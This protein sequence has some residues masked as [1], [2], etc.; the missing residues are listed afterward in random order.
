MLDNSDPNKPSF[1]QLL[2]QEISEERDVVNAT[3]N[4]GKPWATA[5]YQ[6]NFTPNQASYAIN[7][8]DFGKV[9]YVLKETT[10]SWIPYIPVAFNDVSEQ[11]YGTIL[12]WYNNSYAQAFA[13]SEAPEKMAFSRVGVL[14]AQ[15]TVEI[16]PLPQQSVT[17]LI[18]Y[19]PGYMGDDDPLNSAIQMPEHAEMVRLRSAIALLP[20]TS[21]G[22]DMAMNA[23]KRKELAQSFAFQLER[24]EKLFADYIRS[25]NI[26]RMV[27][28]EPFNY[29]NW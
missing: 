13:L 29:G 22:E 16:Q 5:E 25:I 19:L 3:N 1:H 27:D 15:Y 4:S 23:T 12:A 14:N 26:P 21:W 10:N 18:T 17:Y 24:K 11:E 6:L 9:L 2:R 7:V 28:V 8:S 20:Y